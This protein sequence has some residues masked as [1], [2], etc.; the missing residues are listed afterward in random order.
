MEDFANCIIETLR[1]F[2]TIGSSFE[3]ITGQNK[4]KNSI[5]DLYGDALPPIA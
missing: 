3:V 5:T 1:N 2:N 4:I